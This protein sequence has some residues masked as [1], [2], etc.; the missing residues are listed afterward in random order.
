MR[1]IL[2]TLIKFYR[3]CISPLMAPSCRYSPTC[4]E[5]AIEAIERF[6]MVRGSWLAMRR[7]SRCHP[8]H[9]GGHDPVPASMLTFNS[10]KD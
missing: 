10:S 7:I 4:S 6:G 3:Y 1:H 9:E 8:W 2:I 5:Y